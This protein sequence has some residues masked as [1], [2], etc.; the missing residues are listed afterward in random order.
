[1]V[2]CDPPYGTAGGMGKSENRYKRLAAAEEWDNPLDTEKFF[3]LCDRILRTGGRIAMFAQEPY[4][5]N[6]IVGAHHNLP[7]NYRNIWIKD[8]FAN[9]LIVNKAPVSFFEDIVIFTKKYDVSGSHPLRAYAQKVLEFIG[10]PMKEIN[11]ELGHRRAEH[12]FYISSTQFGLCSR[13][14]YNEIT[15][16]YSLDRM[17]GFLEY[18]DLKYIDRNHSPVFNIPEGAKY[19][20]N[21]LEFRKDYGRLHPTQKPVALMEYLIK[22][23]T[24]EGMTVLDNCMGSGTTGVACVN[25][26]RRFIGI[27]QDETYFRI[28]QDRITAAFE[29]RANVDAA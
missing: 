15:E 17:C 12:F 1:M 6:V 25:L 27:E 24:H 28:A 18:D 9:S 10:K 8:H 5:T 20:S 4:T 19:L 16:R 23:Y 21:V 26:N 11:T 2:L 14:V 29:Q 13:V 7:F 3:A 22:T